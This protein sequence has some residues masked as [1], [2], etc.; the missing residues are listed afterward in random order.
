M[1][2]VVMVIEIFARVITRLDFFPALSSRKFDK[3][4]AHA[5]L[6]G[7]SP[8]IGLQPARLQAQSLFVSA[9]SPTSD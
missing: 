8:F 7:L 6:Y 3:F 1:I 2:I 5:P 9:G 4:H